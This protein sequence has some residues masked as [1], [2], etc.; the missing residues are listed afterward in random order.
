MI[1]NIFFPFIIATILFCTSCKKRSS[2][3]NPL[4]EQYFV[5]NILTKNFSVTLAVDTT[6]TLT[7]NYAGETFVLLETDLYHGPMTATKND[8]VYNGTW[9]CNSDYSD[10]TITLPSYPPELAFLSR[11]WKFT[12]KNIPTMKL[13][14]WGTSDPKVLYMT[15]Q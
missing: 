12:S 15:R 14:P 11:S 1:K 5:T 8:T 2:S 9:S 7:A 6:D 10:L 13:A 3:T 4:L